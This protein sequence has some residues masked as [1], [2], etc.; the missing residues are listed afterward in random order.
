MAFALGQ[1]Y[2]AQPEGRATGSAT[3]ESGI[4][5]SPRVFCNCSLQRVY[6]QNGL[7]LFIT[8]DLRAFK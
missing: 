3:L 8:K 7:Y 1:A 4:A 6:W 5:P 2:S